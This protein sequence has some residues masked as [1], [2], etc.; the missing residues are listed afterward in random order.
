MPATGT[1]EAAPAAGYA[2]LIA[3]V[4]ATGITL[5]ENGLK[6]LDEGTVLVSQACLIGNP[7]LLASS[8]AGLSPRRN[9]GR[10]LDLVPVL[11]YH[12][13]KIMPRNAATMP[14]EFTAKTM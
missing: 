12:R 10:P 11:Y 13:K 6:T 2:D 3:D 9:V 4:T 8:P 1:L 5:R 7:D 14:A